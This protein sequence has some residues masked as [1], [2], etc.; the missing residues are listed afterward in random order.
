MC[1][2]TQLDTREIVPWGGGQD[3]HTSRRG[4]VPLDLKHAGHLQFVA[5]PDQ[6]F[7]RLAQ[8]PQRCLQLVSARSDTTR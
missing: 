7:V 3:D 6:P 5:A 8:K 1:D 4:V 2:S